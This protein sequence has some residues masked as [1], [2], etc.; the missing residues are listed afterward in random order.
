M[1]DFLSRF[2]QET[3]LGGK[4]HFRQV[5][6]DGRLYIE[7]PGVYFEI[8]HKTFHTLGLFCL[9]LLDS[10]CEDAVA[11]HYRIDAERHLIDKLYQMDTLKITIR[12][13]TVDVT[14]DKSGVYQL[15]STFRI[16]KYGK[17]ANAVSCIGV[18]MKL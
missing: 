15:N 14:R 2:K 16:G 17:S 12:S 3:N 1:L 10:P 13:K 4:P 8:Q 6:G 11:I 5:Y 7:P 18:W 9:E